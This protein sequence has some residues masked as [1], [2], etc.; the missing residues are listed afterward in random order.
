MDKNSIEHTVPP[1]RQLVLMH[2]KH[3][4]YTMSLYTTLFLKLNLL[5]RNMQKTLKN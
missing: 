3:R 1:T 4:Y 2:E 5:V